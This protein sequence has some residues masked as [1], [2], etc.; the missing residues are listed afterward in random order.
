MTLD[1]FSLKLHLAV[2][3]G[4]IFI[5]PGGGTS[6]VVSIGKGKISYRRKAST[7]AVTIQ[8]LYD[9]FFMFKNSMMASSDLKARWPAVFDSNARPAGHSCNVTFLF[10]CLKEMGLISKIMGRG[11]RGNPYYVDLRNPSVILD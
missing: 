10:L 6:E 8:S 2:V 5:N 3:P 11:V 1:E 7:M 4:M 9:A